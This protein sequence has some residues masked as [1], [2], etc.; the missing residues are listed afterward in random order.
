MHDKKTSIK[1]FS[2]KINII[3]FVSKW[4]KAAKMYKI[5]TINTFLKFYMLLYLIKFNI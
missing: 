5:D 4:N 3:Q 1:I 2:V